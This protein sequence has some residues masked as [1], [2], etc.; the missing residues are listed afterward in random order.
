MNLNQQLTKLDE[1]NVGNIVPTKFGIE[2]IA[3]SIKEQVIDGVLD[4]VDV[5]IK[6]NAV[7]QLSKLVRDKIQSDVID[8]LGK[9]PKQK[10][11]VNGASISIMD[12]VKYDFSHIEEWADLE[13]IIQSAR[14][15]QKE[16]EEEE[17]KWRRGELPIKSASSTFKVQLNK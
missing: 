7:E 13:N 8:E 5:A 14:N 9:Y 2:L 15:R 16:I 17:K 12:S 1:L 10:A 11:E 6:M 4:P 3:E